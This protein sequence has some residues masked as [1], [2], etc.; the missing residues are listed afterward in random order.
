MNSRI[1]RSGALVALTLVLAFSLAACG[2]S[3]KGGSGSSGGSATSSGGSATTSSSG[4][5]SSGGSY[6]VGLVTDIGGLND[7][8]FNHLAY[9]GLLQAESQLGVKGRRCCSR[10]PGADYVPNLTKLAQAG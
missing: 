10:P 1:G 9:E 4:G 7:H 5:S 6:K 8:G 2:S 3:K